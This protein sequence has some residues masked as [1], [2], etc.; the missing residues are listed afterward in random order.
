MLFVKVEAFV[1]KIK[2]SSSRLFALAYVVFFLTV[3]GCVGNIPPF[4][5]G[6]S[7]ERIVV[8]KGWSVQLTADARD[9]ELDILSYEWSAEK[10]E[11]TPSEDDGSVAIWKAPEEPGVY[12]VTVHVSDASQEVE[13]GIKLEV[14][15]LFQLVTN[16]T[17]LN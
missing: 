13:M 15:D 10:G 16:L 3:A 6:I 4:I 8:Q 17:M 1:S 12:K 2:I 5:E 9:L 11:I 14:L 7:P